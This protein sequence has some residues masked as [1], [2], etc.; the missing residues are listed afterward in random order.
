MKRT[1]IITV[2]SLQPIDTAL[3]VLGYGYG[4]MMEVG[5]KKP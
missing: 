5:R 3:V 2:E 4:V 1:G